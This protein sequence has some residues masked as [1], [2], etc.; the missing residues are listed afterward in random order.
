MNGGPVRVALVA[1]L[2][3]VAGCTGLSPA[4]DDTTVGQ[5]TSA[6]KSTTTVLGTTTTTQTTSPVPKPPY[7]LKAI[8]YANETVTVRILLSSPANGTVFYNE[9][10]TLE[11][12]DQVELDH[13]IGNRD[14]FTVTVRL[15]ET[16]SVTK[17]AYEY[18]GYRIVV[19]NESD[20]QISEITF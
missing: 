13:V 16:T 8:S 15:D 6:T 7:R 9:T 19:Q 1:S 3:L 5:S 2:V 14:Q 20:V 4:A 18:D 11:P 10:R 17:T 12:H